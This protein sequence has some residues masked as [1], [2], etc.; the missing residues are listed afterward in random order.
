MRRGFPSAAALALLL[1]LLAGCAGLPFGRPPPP[2]RVSEVA[3]AGDAARRASQRLVLDGLDADER[4]DVERARGSYDRALQV[5]PTNPYAYLALARHR[6]EGTTPQDALPFLDQT[7]SLL[8]V[9]GGIPPR[10]EAHLA[11]LRGEA[12]YATGRVREAIPL[13]EKARKLAPSV[14]SDGHLAPE[15]LE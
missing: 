6:V 11:G 14:W 4:G 5:D 1:T 15:E 13:L 10:L 12:L 7:E 3:D 2:L 9:E 8:G